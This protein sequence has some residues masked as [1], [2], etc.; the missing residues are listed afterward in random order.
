MTVCLALGI[1][2]W[3]VCAVSAITLFPGR[4]RAYFRQVRITRHISPEELP[5]SDEPPYDRVW[6]EPA[7]AL[8]LIRMSFPLLM[9]RQP[10][11]DLEALRRRALRPVWVALLTT[12]L[13]WPAVILSERWICK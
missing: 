3:L 4:G 2:I 5:L 9:R 1:I 13:F 10:E 8:S 7:F 11:L 12:L 6:T